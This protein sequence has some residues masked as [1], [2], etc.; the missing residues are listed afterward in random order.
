VNVEQLRRELSCVRIRG[1]LASRILAEFEDHLSIDPDADLGEPRAIA[2]QF[3]DEL[4]TS[5]ARSA[6]LR[7]VAALVVCGVAILAALP[8]VRETYNWANYNTGIGPLQI[9]W[10]NMGLFLAVFMGQISVAASC[11]AVLGAT[12]LSRLPVVSA[13]EATNLRRRA[14]VAW[15][16]GAVTVAL[17]AL[18]ALV[19]PTAYAASWEVTVLIAA[20]AC[21]AALLTA[22]PSIARAVCVKPTAAGA[23]PDLLVDLSPFLPA[24]AT[25]LLTPWRLAFVFAAAAAAALTAVGIVD[26]HIYRGVLLGVVEGG[27]CLT[28]FS[29]LGRY[30]GM[31]R[32]A[33]E[34]DADWRLE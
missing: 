2:R 34:L 14:A 27:L 18:M 8:T 33:A 22:L 1:R 28:G 13:A 4:G 3:A 23:T 9:S 7:T 24:R 5:L 20:G 15:S 10:F 30:L 12:R 32:P 31:V 29:L 17:L 21:G 6:A 19:V 11:L 26:D 16:S 25:R